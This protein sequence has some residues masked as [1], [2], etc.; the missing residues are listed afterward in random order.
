[1]SV[2][3]SII[4]DTPRPITEVNRTLPRDLSRIVKRCLMK[5]PEERYQSARDIRHD[6]EELKQA[7]ESGLLVLAGVP[8]QTKRSRAAVV[9]VLVGGA[10]DN[11]RL[12][13][14]RGVGS[15]AVADV[16]TSR[17]RDIWSFAEE[18]KLHSVSGDGRQLYFLRSRKEADIWMAT[19]R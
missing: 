11:P 19:L 15:L 17:V 12:L 16:Q 7:L 4:R 10:A 1:M 8:Q 14:T 9:A 6:L 2:L 18:L 3:S 13:F 5:D